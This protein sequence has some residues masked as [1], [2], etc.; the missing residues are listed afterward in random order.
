MDSLAFRL[1]NALVGNDAE[2]AG[3]EVTLSGETQGCK[4][5]P[6][7]GIA[8]TAGLKCLNCSQHSIQVDGALV[9]DDSMGILYLKRI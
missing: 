1:A 8:G 6:A 2:A 3:L 5:C 9:K 4:A 7:W